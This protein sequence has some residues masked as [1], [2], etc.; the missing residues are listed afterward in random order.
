MRAGVAPADALTFAVG[1][2]TCA[3]MM[4]IGRALPIRRALKLDPVQLIRT[5]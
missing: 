1:A 4:A 3:V 2:G 5:E